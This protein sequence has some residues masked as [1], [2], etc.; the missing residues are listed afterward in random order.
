MIGTKLKVMKLISESKKP[1]LLAI[2]T[3]VND[4]P[5]TGVNVGFGFPNGVKYVTTDEN[6]KAR[7][8]VDKF[9]EGKYNVK[10]AFFGNDKYKATDKIPF[11]FKVGRL[12]TKLDIM[13]LVPASKKEYLLATLIDEEGNPV[14][15]VNVGF[16]F[17]DGVKYVATDDKGKARYSIASFKDGRY[18]VKVAFFGDENFKATE[19][20]AFSF[21]R[22]KTP[23]K[24]N[25]WRDRD[26]LIARLNDADNKP[27]TGVKIG[28][29]YNGV[30]YIPTNNNG[31]ATY[32]IN[33]FGY[34]TFTVKVA[35]FG[36]DN[37]KETDKI[38][39]KFTNEPPKPS[40]KKY[41]HSTE[42][43]CDDMGQNNG[44]YCGCHSL[45]EVFRTLTDIVVPQSTIAGWAGTTTSGTGHWGLETAVAKFNSKY[46]KNL[47]V[48]WFN[49]SDLGWSGIKDII[50]SNDKDCIIHNLYRDEWGHYEVINN[51]GDEINVQNSLGSTCSNGC[52][53]GYI[54]YR[55]Q[56]T[57]R[58]YISGISQK[59]VMVITND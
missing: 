6:G 50:N 13:K 9:K 57:Y 7:Y 28:F 48:Q 41:G 1:Y 53:Y 37:Y 32:N 22:G 8:F 24:L 46:G 33:Q 30:K 42:H 59:S 47:K 26:Y 5:V 36:N 14:K 21:W 16:G 45:Q 2:L 4:N 11:A 29:G 10:V 35:F 18:S 55:S 54:E 39:F 27:V 43:C 44:Y 40:K 49:F 17:K 23:T 38:A 51:V 20:I 15:N 56:S 19:K 58:R 31:E 12:G 34:G 52:Y 25:V 3:D